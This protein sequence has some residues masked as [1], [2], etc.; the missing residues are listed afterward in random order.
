M[1]RKR[2]PKCELRGMTQARSLLD[3]I[4]ILNGAVSKPL[5]YSTRIST[6]VVDRHGEFCSTTTPYI[7]G[8]RS[9]VL[10]PLCKSNGHLWLK[11]NANI[12]LVGGYPVPDSSIIGHGPPELIANA[13]GVVMVVRSNGPLK[14][15]TTANVV[16]MKC[17]LN[18]DSMKLSQ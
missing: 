3:E 4:Y 15:S 11:M 8:S 10:Y 14:E 7:P 2:T 16:V 18:P 1:P 9:W 17:W 13:Q 5:W 12:R 6:K